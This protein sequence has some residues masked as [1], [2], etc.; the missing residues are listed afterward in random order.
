MVKTE[1]VQ[2]ILYNFTM[3]AFRDFAEESKRVVLTKEAAREVFEILKS[4]NTLSATEATMLPKP[5]KKALYELLLQYITFTAMFPHLQFPDGFLHGASERLLNAQLLSY[6]LGN[7]WPF[8]Q[9]L[10]WT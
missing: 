1:E 4:I 9:Q 3:Y 8:P 2:E 7:S 10:P 5:H 6:I